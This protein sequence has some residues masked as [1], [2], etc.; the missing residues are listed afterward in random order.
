ML[1]LEEKPEENVMD[2]E[3]EAPKKRKASLKTMKN[4]DGKYPDWMSVKKIKKFK[5][6]TKLKA[7]RNTKE[8]KKARNWRIANSN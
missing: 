1:P 4:A 3:G 8:A 2:I 7:K 5:K 6:I